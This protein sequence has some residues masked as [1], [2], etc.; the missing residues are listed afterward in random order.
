MPAARKDLR[1]PVVAALAAVA[2]MI[3][4]TLWAP[5][6]AAGAATAEPYRPAYHFSPAKN[7][8]NDPNGLVFSKGVYHL[9]F[10]YNPVG[11]QWGNMSW[12]HA[13]S[14][15]L[16]HW[17]EQ[18][19]A[20][21]YDADEGVFSGSVVVD[22]TN[23]S[24]LGTATNPP[25]VAIYTSAYTAASG[26]DGIQAQSLA[27]SL[28]DGRTWTKYSGNPV[29]DLGSREFRDPKVF[30]YGSEWRM[31][32]A[33]PTEHRVAIYRSSNLTQWQRL[34]TFGPLGATSGIWECP[35][36]FPL[37]VDGDSTR[38][39][40]VMLV[41][42][43][44]GSIAGG[45]GTQYFVGDFDG[46]TFRA[47][48]TGAYTPPSGRVLQDF[49]QGYAG[50]QA[51]GTAF[52]SAPAAG[53]LPGQQVVS[54]QLGAGLANSFLGGDGSTGTLTSP[55]F[56]V[57]QRYLN[58][59]VGGGRHPWVPGTSTRGVDPV[60]TVLAGFESTG[61]GDWT[62]TGG[63]AGRGPTA[64][65]APGQAPVTE[66]R[67]AR[68]VNTFLEGDA[69]TGTLAS[70]P[71]TITRSRL[72][73]LV[74]G[75]NHPWG[76]ANPTAVVLKVDGQVVRSATG[77]DSETLAWQTWDVADLVGRQASIEVVDDNTG[78]WGHLLL[79]EVTASDDRVRS[80]ADF[81]G[82]TWD[83]P[84]GWSA[85]G[86]FAAHPHTSEP[87]L[88][89]QE[90][91]RV[92]D[93]CIVPDRCDAATGRFLSPTFRVEDAWVNF[94]LAGGNHPWGS[95]SPTAVNLVVD[96]QVVRTATGPASG[97]M[98]W[99]AWDVRDLAGKDAHLEIVD[100]NAGGD[101]SHLMVDHVVFSSRPADKV[102]QA[103][104]VNLV[105]DGQVVR[106][107]TGQDSESLDW[108]SWDLAD[109][110]GRTARIEVVDAGRGGW[111]HVLAD[112]FTLAGSPALSSVQRAHWVDH[113][114]DNYAGVTFN[115]APAGKRILVG[116]MSNWDYAG[117]VPTS[118]W[119]G[120]M[121]LPR[122]LSLVTAPDGIRLAQQP[123][124]ALWKAAART[125]QSSARSLTGGSQVAAP[126]VAVIDVN[127]DPG[128]ATEAGVVIGDSA[129]A[130]PLR[131]VVRRD[132]LDGQTGPVRLVVDRRQAGLVGFHERFPSVESAPLSTPV[133]RLRIVI[134]RNSVEVFADG[135]R[136]SV[137]DLVLQL[138][139]GR[140]V[141]LVATG[142]TAAQL[143]ATITPL[144]G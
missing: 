96:G 40:W 46:T 112:Q 38:T 29:L 74:G 62:A 33:L 76:Q 128:A 106:S 10:Q 94:L 73:L 23:S 26:R 39:T 77:R 52:G 1:N 91:Q 131:V 2:L 27:F 71:F 117:A 93:T 41:S 120:Q 104:A 47:D 85:D 118:P 119:R 58:F 25:I 88:P 64:G 86:D 130:N 34:S 125:T 32:V 6:A 116:W 24:G 57:D 48:D 103:T 102:A 97:A 133:Q 89:N 16:L 7:W 122:E 15:D 81:E 51:S 142:G 3:G 109:L 44:P 70:A 5:A 110:Q 31:V 105:V 123:V 36:L 35:D 13:T 37:P 95:A 139:G 79:D 63:L 66:F 8:M 22:Q 54:G 84:A 107:A 92:I 134:D 45:S 113:G 59:L 140:T 60:G 83:L 61:W 111:G 136:V 65:A 144:V 90:G 20:I 75:G 87:A 9:F 21:P 143:K 98:D 78:G 30:R 49:E 100:D 126:D 132:G 12:G 55:A 11:D 72:G 56:T 137:T 80:Y 121:T 135:G 18:P 114:R 42:L 99:V 82:H 67:G 68:L 43:N 127:V 19:V 28:D 4:A 50:W 108:T 141:T 69:T 53:T 138:G 129:G 17:T 115:D 101:W 14:T 124:P